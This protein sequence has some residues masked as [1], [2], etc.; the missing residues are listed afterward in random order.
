[1]PARLARRPADDP[2]G[3]VRCCTAAPSTGASRST[4]AASPIAGRAGCSPRSPTGSS[5]AVPR[6]RCCGS[7]SRAGRPGRFGPASGRGHPRGS[8]RAAGVVRRTAGRASRPLDGCP[9]GGPRRRRPGSGGGRR[10]PGT[11]AAGGDP[12]TA[13]AGSHLVAVHGTRDRIT[14]PRATRRYVDRAGTRGVCPARRAPGPRP[15]HAPRAGP[16]ERRRDQGDAGP[17][18]HRG[19][20]HVAGVKPF[21]A[22][23]RSISDSVPDLRAETCPARRG[24]TTTSHASASASPRSPEVP[25]QPPP[26][27]SARRSSASPG[28]SPGPLSRA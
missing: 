7:R 19:G 9:R 21:C 25:W 11:L 4:N 13:L 10:R 5:R 26:P 12:V 2:R 6:S 1:M 24:S 28:P 16:V 27:R 8:C 23:M 18:R 14:S 20:Y 3:V 15:L 17:A 22:G